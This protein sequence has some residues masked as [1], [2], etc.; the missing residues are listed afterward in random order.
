MY[1]V[2]N[3]ERFPEVLDYLIRK[4]IPERFTEPKQK[5]EWVKGLKMQFELEFQLCVLGGET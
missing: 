3:L 2:P 1:L 4:K 5:Y